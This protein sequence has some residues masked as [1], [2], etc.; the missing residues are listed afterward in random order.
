MQG[1]ECLITGCELLIYGEGKMLHGDLHALGGTWIF[2][3]VVKDW[4]PGWI[5]TGEDVNA[6][7]RRFSPY[8]LTLRGPYF[9]RRG[10]IVFDP[11]HCTP[12]PAAMA[13]LRR[14]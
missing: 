2:N 7:P 11:L 5:Y 9:E 12:N 10:V 4:E 3:G 6:I 14:E 8:V 1:S 13:Y